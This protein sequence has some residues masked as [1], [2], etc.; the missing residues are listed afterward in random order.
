MS[1]FNKAFKTA[2]AV[3]LASTALTSYAFGHD[4]QLNEAKDLKN[5]DA[6]RQVAV[7]PVFHVN[8]GYPKDQNIE[9][10]AWT[11]I[12]N[13]IAETVALDNGY[14][15]RYTEANRELDLLLSVPLLKAEAYY[16]RGATR[17]ALVEAEISPLVMRPH[18][19]QDYNR[20]MVIYQQVAEKIPPEIKKMETEYAVQ[21]K[22][23]QKKGDP[24]LK[25][26]V[27]L[28]YYSVNQGK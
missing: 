4:S 25:C 10:R 26:Q 7:S 1:L 12:K 17:E 9:V 2:A 14:V 28:A 20:L 13:G 11:G 18:Q 19:E 8:A 27:L 24:D 5:D 3:I 21:T 22:C 15:L 23:V 6:T 16:I